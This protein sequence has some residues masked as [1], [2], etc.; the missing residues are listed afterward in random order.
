VPLA[1]TDCGL[2]FGRLDPVDGPSLS[3]GKLPDEASTGD[4]LNWFAPPSGRLRE[5]F[6]LKATE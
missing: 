6:N 3:I 5:P 2:H 1:F 4:G